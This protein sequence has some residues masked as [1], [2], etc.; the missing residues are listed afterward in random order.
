MTSRSPSPSRVAGRTCPTGIDRRHASVG[1]G[2]QRA[3]VGAIDALMYASFLPQAREFVLHLQYPTLQLRNLQI[4]RGRMRQ[5]LGDFL[6]E[7]LMP[8]FQL[9]KMRL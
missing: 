7:S 2:E 1:M 5:S 9:R 6:I 4:V 3:D 8:P